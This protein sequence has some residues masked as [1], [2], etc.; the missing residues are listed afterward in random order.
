VAL[1]LPPGHSGDSAEAFGYAPG[2]RLYTY[3]AASAVERV[4]SRFDGIF[5]SKAAA[6]RDRSAYRVFFI[7]GS[8]AWGMKMKDPDKYFQVLERQVQPESGNGSIRFLPAAAKGINST[9]ESILYNF[10]V[11]PLDPDMV[12]LFD[13]WNDVNQ[14]PMFGVRPGDPYNISTVYSRSE[15]GLASIRI[16]MA[17][18]LESYRR[19]FLNGYQRNIKDHEAMLV[20]N[21]KLRSALRD[22]IVAVYLNNVEEMIKT[23]NGRGIP[24]ILALQ[25]CADWL[26]AKAGKTLSD[27]GRFIA[28]TYDRILAEIA[29]RPLLAENHID[30]MTAVERERFVDPVHFDREGNIQ[31]AAA[32]AAGLQARFP[33]RVAIKPGR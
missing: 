22:G 11:L 6:A 25:P 21:G 23:G 26:D 10:A 27:R 9:Q 8:T 14:V 32:L 33:F 2:R 20:E 17:D 12:V 5:Q 13:G 4:G 24:V 31:A 3:T 19:F 28:E 1:K 16:W 29:R 18:H 15:P 30:L 7:G